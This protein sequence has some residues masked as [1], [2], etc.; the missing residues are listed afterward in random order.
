MKLS[1]AVSIVRLPS[2]PGRRPNV[3]YTCIKPCVN[4][5]DLLLPEILLRVV[6][7]SS[8]NPALIRR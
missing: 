1:E 4:V 6:L 7:D 5:F 2:H 3:S 8:A